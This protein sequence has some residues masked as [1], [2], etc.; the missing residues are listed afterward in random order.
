MS[1]TN[2][3]PPPQDRRANHATKLNYKYMKGKKEGTK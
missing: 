2:L 1:W 3:L